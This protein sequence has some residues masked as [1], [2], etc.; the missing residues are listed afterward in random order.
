M[1]NNTIELA[2]Q[3]GQFYLQ[4]N[5]GD[6]EKTADEISKLRIAEI[7]PIGITMAVIK[8]SRVGLMIGKRGEDIKH[9]EAFVNRKLF[10]VEHQNI[11]D[12]IIPQKE[13]H[14]NYSGN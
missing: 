14:D 1:D 8:T 5:N 12:W 2:E 10:L 7:I 11:E 13:E 9:L 6:Y 3:I 4:R